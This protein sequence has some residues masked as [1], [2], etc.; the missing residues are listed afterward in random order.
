MKAK[1]NKLV[2][3]SGQS[4]LHEH[5]RTEHPQR[6]QAIVHSGTMNAKKGKK[7]TSFILKQFRGHKPVVV[8]AAATT[9]LPEAR[10]VCSTNIGDREN[11]IRG[12]ADCISETVRILDPA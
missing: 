1:V 4:G 2:D 7:T 6:K 8:P 10:L 11:F 12:L 3:K 5:I 9:G